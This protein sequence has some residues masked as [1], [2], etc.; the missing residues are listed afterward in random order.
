MLLVKDKRRRIPEL[1]RQRLSLQTKVRVARET[2]RT[3]STT[4]VLTCY[5]RRV[6]ATEYATS[7]P[8]LCDRSC[9]SANV[10]HELAHAPPLWPA[11]STGPT[12]KDTRVFTAHLRYCTTEV[13]N[14]AL[15]SKV[16]V[17]SD[18]AGVAHIRYD[19][20]TAAGDAMAKEVKELASALSFK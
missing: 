19:P 17:F 9:S 18:A 7:L 8:N 14:F 1:K 5:S 10:A 12:R 4:A 3:Q 20:E 2:T 16:L 13:S 11:K 15:N 6:R